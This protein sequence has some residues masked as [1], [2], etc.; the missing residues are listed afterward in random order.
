[1]DALCGYLEDKE[2]EVLKR[3]NIGRIVQL[4]YIPSN[5]INGLNGEAKEMMSDLNTIREWRRQRKM[6]VSLRDKMLDKY[7]F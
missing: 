6:Y 2:K 7:G 3:L 4:T 1:M 5:L